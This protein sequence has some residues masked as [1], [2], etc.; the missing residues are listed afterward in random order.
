MLKHA[1]SLPVSLSSTP[2]LQIAEKIV[3]LQAA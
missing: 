3:S 1:Y 2:M